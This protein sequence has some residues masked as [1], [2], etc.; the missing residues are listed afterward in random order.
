MTVRFLSDS[1]GALV[2]VGNRR[3]ENSGEETNVLR[4]LIGSSC[5][6][7]LGAMITAF[8]EWR[9]ERLTFRRFFEAV[10][11]MSRYTENY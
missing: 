1:N 11:E 6:Q 8:G 2:R 5:G 10:R 7:L 4:R 3:K 9:V